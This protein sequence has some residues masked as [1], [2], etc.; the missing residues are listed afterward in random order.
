L[1]QPVEQVSKPE[2]TPKDLATRIF[3]NRS[4]Q[5]A[6]AIFLF[7]F[8][9]FI[10]EPLRHVILV[11]WVYGKVAYLHGLR[12]IP[13]KPLRFSNGIVVPEILDITTAFGMFF[14]TVLGLSLTAFFAIR[15][16]ERLFRKY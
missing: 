10:T 8:L 7:L 3:D 9:I 6:W 12:V 4:F 13:Q 11:Y 5:G 16:Y 2:I 1:E 15:F 14:A